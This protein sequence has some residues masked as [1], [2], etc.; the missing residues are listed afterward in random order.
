MRYSVRRDPDRRESE[1][2]CFVHKGHAALFVRALGRQGWR[3]D[4]GPVTYVVD[5]VTGGCIYDPYGKLP[6]LLI[7]VAGAEFARNE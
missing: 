1:I 3:R 5:T 6:G 4:R 7:E 2:A